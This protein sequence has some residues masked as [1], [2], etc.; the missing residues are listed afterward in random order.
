MCNLISLVND[1]RL[2]NNIKVIFGVCILWFDCK[3]LKYHFL[4]MYERLMVEF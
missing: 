4:K 2:N 1:N 3:Q